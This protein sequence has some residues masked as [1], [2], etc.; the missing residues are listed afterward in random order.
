MTEKLKANDAGVDVIDIISA[1]IRHRKV[2][3]GIPVLVAVLAYALTHLMSPRYVAKTVFMP[4][5]QQQITAAAAAMQ[6]LGALAGV[7]GGGIKN[8]VD[9]YI[10]LMLSSTVANRVIQQFD[11]K[12][13]YDQTSLEQTRR[14]LA[15]QVR[16]E[17]GKKDGL[18]T[19]QVEDTNPAMAAD[20]A[21]NYVDQLRKLTS[22]FVM[23][24]AQQ[25]RALFERQLHQTREKL[26][27]AQRALQGSGINAGVLRSEPK[28][29]AE[30]FASIKAQVTAAELRLK[31]LRNYLTEEAPEYKLALS[32]LMA[33][34]AELGKAESADL[35][36][37]GG[38]YVGRYREFK[39][40]EMLFELFAKQFELAKL[41]ET[42]EGA[43]IQVVDVAVPPEDK[44]KPKRGMITVSAT[45]GSI[46]AMLLFVLVR[47][48]IR[49]KS[50]ELVTPEKLAKLKAAW[51]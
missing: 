17:G 35:G 11:L 7:A 30:T 37:A 44:S 39:Y 4:P 49:M 32:N 42:R 8:P 12:K 24:E 43:V 9:Q 21:N 13:H 33:L 1:L 22:E 45:F 10:A 14:M 2:L 20:I 40:Q 36:A 51:K 19:V 16:I 18:I 38:D 48:M 25:R 23:T 15:T 27:A 6:S 46:F 3:I 28:A 31:S 34:R 50:S 47:E 29:A 5:Q 26:T 41:D